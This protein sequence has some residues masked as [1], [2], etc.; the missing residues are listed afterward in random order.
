MERR[1]AGRWHEWS[2]GFGDGGGVGAPL[3]ARGVA[4]TVGAMVGGRRQRDRAE[5]A[6]TRQRAEGFGRVGLQRAV[7]VRHQPRKVAPGFLVG[8]EKPDLRRQQ[9]IVLRTG[10]K[11][12]KMPDR[13][14]TTARTQFTIRL[15]NR[16]SVTWQV[17]PNTL[18]PSFPP[19]H[20][21]R[22]TQSCAD[23]RAA[24][25]HPPLGRRIHH[26]HRR[27]QASGRPGRGTR[28]AATPGPLR[29]THRTRKDAPCSSVSRAT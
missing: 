1:R 5:A 24:R 20:R 9:S 22:A 23:C 7:F 12:W 15:R 21:R 17:K 19:P 6:L 11:A 18:P 16:F 25:V 29:D 3:A 4:G 27:V 10:N 14:W 28:P 26:P 8:M 13:E 2:V